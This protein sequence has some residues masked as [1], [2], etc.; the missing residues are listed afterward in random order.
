MKKL[1]TC[2]AEKKWV[3]RRPSKILSRKLLM[4]IGDIWSTECFFF[5]FLVFE[6]VQAGSKTNKILV[7]TIDY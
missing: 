7:R 5:F 3:E 4:I 2:I 1:E 6:I